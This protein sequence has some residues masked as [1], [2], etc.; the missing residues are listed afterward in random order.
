MTK[1]RLHEVVLPRRVK[2]QP[3]PNINPGG[4][5]GACVLGGALDVSVEYVYDELKGERQSISFWEMQ[6]M[7]RVAESHELADRIIEQPA[8]FKPTFDGGGGF[9]A[10]GTPAYFVARDWHRYVQ[11]AIDAGYYGI[12]E[13]DYGRKGLEGHG[14][15]HW[16]L[17]CGARIGIKWKTEFN[18]ALNKDVTSGNYIDDVLV[19]CSARPTGMK[20]EW[21]DAH[22]FLKY[23]GGYNILFVR[24][25]IR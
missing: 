11:M 4:D 9:S 20:D 23:R 25:T 19:S 2:V 17:I 15:N 6:R 3:T 7:L 21:V 18:T 1:D 12:A 13:V 8:R 14:T 10:F 24:P 16:V 5:C 22:D